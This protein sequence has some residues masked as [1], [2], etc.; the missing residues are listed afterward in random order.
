ME[1]NSKFFDDP[2]PEEFI[3]GV[4]GLVIKRPDGKLA[5]II[6]N[7]CADYFKKDQ[8]TDFYMGMCAAVRI[9]ATYEIRPAE[10]KE[11]IP[12]AKNMED[13]LMIFQNCVVKIINDRKT[14]N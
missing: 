5:D 3:A 4:A 9:M 6:N 12:E 7:L 2:P 13:M 8:S 11:V 10:L 14:F 1:D